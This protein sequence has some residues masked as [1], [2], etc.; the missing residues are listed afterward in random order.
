MSQQKSSGRETAEGHDQSMHCPAYVLVNMICLTNF[1]AIKAI[2]ELGRQR[3]KVIW[4]DR[5]KYKAGGNKNSVFNLKFHR[6]GIYF[7]GF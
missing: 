7:E 3:W 6:Y 2:P 5:E 4:V 1:Q